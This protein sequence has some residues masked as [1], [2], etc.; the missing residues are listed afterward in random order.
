[1]TNEDF[2]FSGKDAHIDVLAFYAV[3]NFDWK[4]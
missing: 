1:M 3:I 4:V 2:R